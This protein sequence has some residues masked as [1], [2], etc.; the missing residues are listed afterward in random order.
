M[1][2]VP[3]PKKKPDAVADKRERGFNV[4]FGGANKI[5]ADELNFQK[6]QEENKL[7]RYQSRN[8]TEKVYRDSIASNHMSQLP[9]KVNK[10]ASKNRT[11]DNPLRSPPTISS[12]LNNRVKEGDV[13]KEAR[14][15]NR[16]TRARGGAQ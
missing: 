13:S 2:P 10:W 16:E 3:K 12:R 14:K 8:K 9:V 11:T 5:L 7:K 4:Y 1:K 6:K 15:L